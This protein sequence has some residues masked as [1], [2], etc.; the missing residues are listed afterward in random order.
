MKTILRLQSTAELCRSA[1]TTQTLGRGVQARVLAKD[2]KVGVGKARWSGVRL[3]V[4]ASV[5]DTF[6]FFKEK[7]AE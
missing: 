7:W 3:H 4:I 1:L 2:A 6:I 5:N